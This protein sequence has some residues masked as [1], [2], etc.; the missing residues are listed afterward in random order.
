[1]D[2]NIKKDNAGCLVAFGNHI[3]LFKFTYDKN[4]WYFWIRGAFDPEVIKGRQFPMDFFVDACK[5]KHFLRVGGKLAEE[6]NIISG[7]SYIK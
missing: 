7:Q 5:A 4:S 1:M 3:A 6:I 2:I